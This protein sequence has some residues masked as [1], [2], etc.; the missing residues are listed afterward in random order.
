M[1]TSTVKFSN[2][3]TTTL[4]GTYGTGDTA[5]T[6]SS[7]AAF[8]I[9]SG[10]T[11]WFYAV[12]ADSLSAPTKREIVKV[13]NVAGSI[14]TVTR[15]QDGTTAQTW[16]TGSYIELRAVNKALQDLY[17]EA[18]STATS[19]VSSLT[20]TTDITITADSDNNGTGSV[21]VKSGPDTVLE[22][23]N[24]GELVANP[25]YANIKHFGGDPTGASD[26]VAAF[27]AAIAAGYTSIYFPKGTYKFLSGVS[28][29][30]QNLT[31]FGD[32]NQNTTLFTSGA[33][34]FDLINF[35]GRY[36]KLTTDVLI[37]R[38]ICL[39]TRCASGSPQGS[40]IYG[41]I[42]YPVAVN[43][44][45]P[46]SSVLI[47]NV[48]ITI[49]VDSAA[50]EKGIELDTCHMAKISNVFVMGFMPIG[51][52]G[53]RSTICLD[54]Y[55]RFP[56]NNNGK[57]TDINI[58]NCVLHQ[59]AVGVQINHTGVPDTMYVEGVHVNGCT[60]LN[61]TK[62]I[63]LGDSSVGGYPALDGLPG[64]FFAGNHIT[65]T[66]VAIDIQTVSQF[67]IDSNLIYATGG[68]TF[69]GIKVT[70]A[71]TSG[72]QMDGLISNNTIINPA[73]YSSNTY[74]VNFISADA[75]PGTASIRVSNN[76]FEGFTTAVIGDS[77]ILGVTVTPDNRVLSGGIYSLPFAGNVAGGFSGNVSKAP[78][79]PEGTG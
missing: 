14:F 56:T 43:W 63:L 57:A 41:I 35:T 20:S 66:D 61:C 40:A 79:A 70:T 33:F 44:P 11:S 30:N 45:Q 59:G 50:W 48:S 72:L 42:N 6:V 75:S 22:V 21:I 55:S 36:Q 1:T 28:V 49:G 34:G 5:L 15:A 52:G 69:S 13:T 37:V 18:V 12:I 19:G 7:A 62:G 58:L 17:D 3:A 76:S 54:I 73:S 23:K 25:G 31:I 10:G 68:T 78:R 32:G 65:A 51:A 27:N 60:I 16:A 71:A 64:W 26:T 46:I 53:A 47:D 9:V 29:T 8:P 67:L 2:F 38:D 39:E 77:T 74:G 4:V 24:N